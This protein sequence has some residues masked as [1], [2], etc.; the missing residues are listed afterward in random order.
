MRGNSQTIDDLAPLRQTKFIEPLE[1]LEEL[2]SQSNRAF[3]LG[4]GCSKCAGLPL[5]QELTNEVQQN[6]SKESKTKTILTLVTQRFDGAKTATIEDFMSEIVDLI[7]IAERRSDRSANHSTVDLGQNSYVVDDML[8]ALNEIKASIAK[9]VTKDLDISTHKQFVKAVHRT[10][11]T[12]KFIPSRPVDYFI[13]NYD[14]LI[15][16]A[17]ALECIPYTDGFNGGPTG[18]WDISC[19]ESNEVAARVLKV[20]GSI[21]WCLLPDD[22]LPRRIRAELKT[23]TQKEKVLIWPA[24][25]KYRE[26]QRDPYAQIMAHLR[27]S[28]RPISNSQIVL[29][30]CG[31]SFGDSHI[32]IEIDRALHESEGRLTVL[33]FTALDRPEDHKQLKTWIENPAVRDQVRI[34]SKRGF[35]HEKK[36]I[37]SDS[38]LLWWKFETLTRLL[39]GER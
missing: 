33:V 18:W 34:H 2:I 10:L 11:R 37:E 9:C 26:T 7:A 39:G 35:F 25:T 5:M 38:D 3:L 4:A 20:H 12:G 36:A 32:N 16:D 28:L 23:V 29:T 13:L 21:D 27:K 19:L 17:L 8:T 15:E 31:Y 1:K 22:T 6:L 30:I 24:A 14:T